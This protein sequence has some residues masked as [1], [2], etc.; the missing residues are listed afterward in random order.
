VPLNSAFSS[1]SSSRLPGDD[2]GLG[3]GCSRPLRC[4]GSPSGRTDP[5]RAVADRLCTRSRTGDRYAVRHTAWGAIVYVSFARRRRELCFTVSTGPG[6]L[7]RSPFLVVGRNGAVGERNRLNLRQ[8]LPQLDPAQTRSSPAVG[9]CSAPMMSVPPCFGP[10]CC[11][12]PDCFALEPHA[13]PTDR[14]GGEAS[15]K[16]D[17]PALS[18][19]GEASSLC[20]RAC[21]SRAAGPYDEYGLLT[22]I[23]PDRDLL[24]VQATPWTGAVGDAGT[25][26]QR[27]DASF[28]L[29]GSFGLGSRASAPCTAPRR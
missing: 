15:E 2:H 21:H 18:T 9:S 24:H 14:E 11:V 12:V 27:G 3:P 26:D 13:R 29:G 20:R 16:A 28:E 4:R 25:R 7:F 22:S 17:R 8:P 10:R 19:H 6:T 1:R 5:C 23:C